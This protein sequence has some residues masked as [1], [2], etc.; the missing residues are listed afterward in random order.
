LIHI[1]QKIKS[2]LE[3]S[4]RPLKT[5]LLKHKPLYHDSTQNQLPN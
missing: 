4:E 5:V 2:T 1:K 3:F